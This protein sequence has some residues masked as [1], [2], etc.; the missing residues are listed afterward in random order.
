MD[1]AVKAGSPMKKREGPNNGLGDGD[2]FNYE[3]DNDKLGDLELD[4][5]DNLVNFADN[6]ATQLAF[7][8]TQKLKKLGQSKIKNMN[9]KR[10]EM[11]HDY[12]K[13]KDILERYIQSAPFTRFSDK[14]TFIYGVLLTIAQAFILGRYPHTYY[15]TFHSIVL[16]GKV[17]YKWMYYKTKGWHYYM[18]DFCYAANT[19]LLVF[20]NVF[21][22][23]EELYINAYMYSFGALLVAVGT[24]RN[25]M[26]F[27]SSDNMSSLAL[28]L[29]P[30]VV[31][32]NVHWNTVEFEKD[33]P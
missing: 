5:L 18:A 19:L 14:M 32:H 16:P 10:I 2:V 8:T 7:K 9:E 3:L 22:K 31:M 20:L 12:K 23:C 29:F 30:A 13:K 6:L 15:Y 4:E 27:H 28:H 17:I 33:L 21:P 26:V 1:E 24:F 11:L 25:Q